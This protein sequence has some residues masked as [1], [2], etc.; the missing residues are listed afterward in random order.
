M[1]IQFTAV[2]PKP[3]SK[4]PVEERAKARHA[5]TNHSARSRKRAEHNITFTGIDGEGINCFVCNSHGEVW[6]EHR[7]VMLGIGDNTYENPSGLSFN[8]VC[9]ALYTEFERN[10]SSVY[11]GFYLGY[12]FTQWLKTLPENRAR[13][14]LCEEDIAKRKRTRSNDNPTPFPVRYCDFEF[15]ILG[16]KRFKLRRSLCDKP[17]CDKTCE[18]KNNPW[19]YVCDAGAFF[20]AS[21]LVSISPDNWVSPI[22]TQEEYEVIK[23]GKEKR[24]TAYLG[25][26][27]RRYNKLENEVLARMMHELN[28]G[29]VKA[30]IKLSKDAWFGPGQAAQAWMRLQKEIPTRSE[31]Q[32]KVPWQALDDARRTYFGGW[33]EIFMH[34]ILP[35]VSYEYDINSAYPHII[36]SLPCLMHGKWNYR[37]RDGVSKN[38]KAGKMPAA[39]GPIYRKLRE[40]RKRPAIVSTALPDLSEGK[41]RYVLATV[42]G[43]DPYIGAM[44][45]RLIDGS[46]T[47]PSCTRGWFWQHELEAAQR[48][49]IID[50]I[51]CEEWWT[52]TPCDCKPPV[53]GLEGLY[54]ERLRVGKD[55]AQGKGYKLVYNSDYGKFAQTIGEPIYGNAVYSSLITAGCRTM[56]LDAIATH[57][58]RTKAVAMVATDGIYFTS[59]H[60]GLPVSKS[61][62]EWDAKEK[63]NLT[64]FKPGVYWDDKAREAI[65]DGSRPQ[66]K[67]RGVS[68]QSFAAVIDDIDAMFR[69]WS[70]VY[71]RDETDW[72]VVKFKLGFNMVTCLQALRRGKWN[73][74]GVVSDS[75]V[76]HKSSP[77]R[78]RDKGWYDGKFYRSSPYDGRDKTGN[79]ETCEAYS[80][81]LIIKDPE[82]LGTVTPDGYPNQIVKEVLGMG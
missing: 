62:G 24:A 10:P 64:L 80:K 12:D 66:F 71:P 13:T 37:D 67:A 53:R 19:M 68:A 73:T 65:R 7:Y 26:D 23:T 9:T 58:Q 34:G 79:I 47:R 18:H 56:I 31:L 11:V 8:E 50:S 4:L 17:F 48:A 76:E 70:G 45:H 52:Y 2:Q 41:I 29:F 20:Q 5:A 15:D 81:G 16:M 36:R 69:E 14:L 55:T 38:V 63:V 21:L 74:A 60:P 6:Q 3:W 82:L 42:K 43:S 28:T 44:L 1:P 72:P 61:L 54:A 25:E 32:A 39:D 30:G 22:A 33:F 27:M 78:K 59:P 51:K 77:S 35:G 57:P 40:R 46:V 49:G 75:E